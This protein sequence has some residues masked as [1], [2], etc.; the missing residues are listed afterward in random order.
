MFC[1]HPPDEKGPVVR[2][3]FEFATLLAARRRS[4]GLSALLILAFLFASSV[5]AL[6][7]DPPTKEAPA[8]DVD[9]NRKAENISWNPKVDFKEYTDLRK[10]SQFAEFDR[11]LGLASVSESDRKLLLKHLENQIYGLTLEQNVDRHARIIEE[12]ATRA[13]SPTTTPAVR[14]FILENTLKIAE[15]LLK[16]QPPNVQHAVVLL[17]ARLNAKVADIGG[18]KK[19]PAQP[20]PGSQKL[21]MKVL[22]Q[23]D[24]VLPIPAR[25]RAARGLERLMRDGDISSVEK[26][27]MGV[28]LAEALMKQNV[29][30]PLARR[31]YRRTL[32]EALGV[33]GRYEDIGYRPYMVD[34]LASVLVNPQDDWEVRAAAARSLSQLPL[35]QKVNVELLNYEI[36][37]LLYDLAQAYNA[38]DK[39]P[40]STWRWAFD[41]IYLSYKSPTVADQTVRHWGLMHLASP[42]GREKINSAYKVVLPIVKPILESPTLPQVNPAAI[43]ALEDWLKNNKPADRKPTKDS[44]PLPEPAGPAGVV[45]PTPMQQPNISAK[46]DPQGR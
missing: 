20:Y 44:A 18:N 6:A 45:A 31:W 13:E 24:P 32:V 39:T 1:D 26:A 2:Q 4:A 29:E 5:S 15:P 30:N 41:T 7:Q 3:K 16:D 25:I 38:S 42:V 9:A 21:M 33:T 35:D 46:T 22:S 40:P 19:I 43:K 12:I 14:E 11:K 8:D 36:V 17:A 37:K 28:A 34:A 10:K 23:T 27:N